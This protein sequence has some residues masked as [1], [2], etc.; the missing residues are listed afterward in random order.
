MKRRDR[1]LGLSEWIQVRPGAPGT[2]LWVGPIWA[3]LCGVVASG[4]RLEVW[5]RE[6]LEVLI[7]VLLAGP[8]AGAINALALELGMTLGASPAGDG[9]R[10][11]EIG[12]QLPYAVPRSCAARLSRMVA[13]AREKWT[14]D[15]RGPAVEYVAGIVIVS[16]IALVLAGLL[17]GTVFVVMGSAIAVAI[18]LGVAGRDR[19]LLFSSQI[20]LGWLLGHGALGQPDHLSVAMSAVLAATYWSALTCAAERRG[21]R[22][23]LGYALQLSGVSL[24]IVAGVPAGA[25]GLLLM[26]IAQ[27]LFRAGEWEGVVYA[28]RVQPLIMLA[29]LIVSTGVGGYIG[30]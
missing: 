17:N 21:L 13:D 16:T 27:L 12:R 19:W 20:M 28:R 14:R 29:M 2:V 15:S 1:T 8:V 11:C 5:T 30:G 22:L 4:T 18:A 25:G 7:A 26:L 9:D 10:G 3:T 6:A 24:L 23:S